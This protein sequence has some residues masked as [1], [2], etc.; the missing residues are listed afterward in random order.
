MPGSSG[1]GDDL[2]HARVVEFVKALED[3]LAHHVRVPQPGGEAGLPP[4]RGL[5]QVLVPSCFEMLV[6]DLGRSDLAFPVIR[7]LDLEDRMGQ[8]LQRDWRDI[9]IGLVGDSVCLP[10]F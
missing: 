7:Q 6:V 10:A 4:A 9:Q 8:L 1:A 5:G 3:V 2:D